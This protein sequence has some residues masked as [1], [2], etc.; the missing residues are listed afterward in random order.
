MSAPSTM[1]TTSEVAAQ[2]RIG[3]E[4]ARKLMQK[5]RGVITLPPLNG[6]GKN[7]TRRMPKAVFDS[8]L[9]QRS[10]QLRKARPLNVQRP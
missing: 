10:N 7:E 6:S 1:L 8:L 2:L 4:A 5:T 9:A 3:R